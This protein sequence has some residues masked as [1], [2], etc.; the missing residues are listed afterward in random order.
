LAVDQN[1]PGADWQTAG[2]E[3][4]GLNREKLAEAGRWQAESARDREPYR[5][6]I[7]RR[8]KIAAEWN[9]LVDPELALPQA[10]ASKS[11]Y[12]TVLGIAVEE[13]VVK[14]ADDRVVEYY[15][16]L[17]DVPPGT[18]PKAGRHA[19]P[20]NEGITFRQLIGN[21][22]GYMKPDEPPGKVFNYQTFGM[23]LLTHAVAA[24]YN[25]YRT[26]DPERGGGFGTLTEWKVRNPIGGAWTWTWH[27]FKDNP[28][29]ARPGTWGFGTQFVMT[30][31]DMARCGLLWLRRGDW[32]GTQIVP[33]NWINDAT[34]VNDDVLRNAPQ[35]VHMYG[36]GFWCN[37]RGK[38]WPDLP[39]DC[40]AA[41]GNGRQCVWVCPSLDLIV[42][43]SPGTYP[44][45]G[46][47]ESP[48]ESSHRRQMQGLLG[49]IADSVAN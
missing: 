23:N 28:S 41:L 35:E 13:G 10:S 39:R 19:Y 15:P 18:G 11:T 22:S 36:L 43:Q 32:N 44:Q 42:V 20:E 2:P 14:S 6:L 31:R 5:I 45:R 47:F 49:R 46:N 1:W 38:A 30:P 7:A 17:M 24:A 16:E 26:S 48:E 3:E 9:F 27:N 37:D 34:R 25:L 21:T 8:G 4:L 33:A 12:S 29:L 40:F